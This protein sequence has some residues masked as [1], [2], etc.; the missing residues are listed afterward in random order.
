LVL[1]SEKAGV[2][3]RTPYDAISELQMIEMKEEVDNLLKELGREEK[4]RDE[5]EYIE[6]KAGV[7][8][9]KISYGILTGTGNI[10]FFGQEH[11]YTYSQQKILHRSDSCHTNRCSCDNTGSKEQQEL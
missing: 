3:N 7:S 8:K 1:N 6:N 10:D 9:P 11:E 5:I 2:I 4:C